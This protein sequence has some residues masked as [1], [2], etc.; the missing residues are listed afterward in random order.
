MTA[1][2]TP[3]RLRTPQFHRFIASLA[4]VT[5]LW[6]PSAQGQSTA[7]TK[8][9]RS[10]ALVKILD[11]HVAALRAGDPIGSSRNGFHEFDGLLPNVS[12]EWIAAQDQAAT[13]RLAR[14]NRLDPKTFTEEDVVDAGIV[15]QSLEVWVQGIPF[16]GEQSPVTNREGPQ[17]WI[18]QLQDQTPVNTPA[19][20]ESYVRRLEA[21]PAF[22]EGTTQRMREGLA[23]KR[24]PPRVIVVGAEEQCLAMGDPAFEKD[25]GTSRLFA[26]LAK[27]PPS[28]PLRDRAAQAIGAGVTPA[29]RRF[30][31]FLKDEYIP[32]CRETLG[33]SQSVDGPASYA[34]ALRT[35]TTT[36][37]S[38][39]AIHALGLSEV[40]RIRAEM[41]ETIGRSDFPKNGRTGDALFNAFVQDLRTNPR[42]YH[43]SPEAML[44]AYRDLCKRI[45]AELPKL[46]G[47]LPRNAYGVKEL[48]AIAQ[49]TGPNAYYFIGSLKGGLPGYFMVNTYRLDQRPTYEMVS[50]A[51][52]EAVPGHH[53]QYALAQEIEGVHPIR[54]VADYTAF[55]EGWALY[56]ER[57]GL[58][59]GEGPHGFYEDPYTD[60]GRL[61]YEMWR[62]CRLV[63][64]TGVHAKGWTR[65]HAIDFMLQNTALSPLNIEREV[66]RYIS[67]AGQACGYKIGELK[68]REL[69]ARAEKALG[70]KFDR[71]QFH[72][73]VL[74]AGAVPLTV[75]EQRV[76]R[77]IER[78]K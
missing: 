15:R 31:T 25:P 66:D 68:V 45:D 21:V 58:E 38:A 46:F 61:T 32:R 56:A 71:R 22:L 13:D 52:H 41:F 78:S 50:L 36:D 34:L 65:Q 30:G 8:P 11:E 70:R 2:L 17:M 64:D 37:L 73:V 51:L 62:A 19:D 54:T 44:T 42:F 33:Q 10:A 5:G 26:P 48:P 35:H 40:A 20:L 76:D 23:A 9:A 16:H 67:W 24:V 72:D 29:F 7:S 27:L 55:A 18:G 28:D 49:A 69:R 59:M 14:L 12:L 77:W 4:L 57:L 6:L 43:K 47:T 74:G 53:H 1:T 63:V 3:R 60:F 39:D 75:L